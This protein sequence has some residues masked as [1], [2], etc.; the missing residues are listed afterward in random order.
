MYLS[1]ALGVSKG[2][3]LDPT[4]PLRLGGFELGVEATAEAIRILE[5][6]EFPRQ[7][8][9]TERELDRPIYWA[10]RHESEGSAEIFGF[11]LGTSTGLPTAIETAMVRAAAAATPDL[12]EPIFRGGVEI[13]LGQEAA[14]CDFLKIVEVSKKPMS[15]VSLLFEGSTEVIVRKEASTFLSK[16]PLDCLSNSFQTSPLKF[17]FLEL[18]RMMEAR[19]LADVKNKLLANF[20]SEPGAALSDAAAALKSEM[21]QIAGLAENQQEAFETFWSS[22]APIKN[23]NRFVAALFKKIEKKG[24]KGG[25]KWKIGA[26]LVYQIRCAVVHAGSKDMIF[27]N[28]DDG[29]EAIEAIMLD[30]ERASL[31]LVGVELN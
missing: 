14:L 13:A 25:G 16:I 5:G 23:T 6:G 27:E 28:F 8:R 1:E 21:D 19:F 17:R 9:F 7:T 10:V 22:L 4:R 29:Q 30:M 26:A 20:D 31:L 2:T 18:Y 11:P 24:L 15:G 12:H 3:D